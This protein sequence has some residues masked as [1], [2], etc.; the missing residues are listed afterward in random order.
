MQDHVRCSDRNIYLLGWFWKELQ[1]R[2]DELQAEL[3]GIQ[4]LELAHQSHGQPLSEELQSKSPG[5]ESDPGRSD[6]YCPRYPNW[7]QSC[8]KWHL[9]IL[10]LFFIFQNQDA[11][12]TDWLTDS[13]LDWLVPHQFISM[14]PT[15]MHLYHVCLQVLVRMRC[16]LSAWVW[17]LR[18]CWSSWRSSIFMK[19]RICETSLKARFVR[20]SPVFHVSSNKF[21][22]GSSLELSWL[23]EKKC[24]PDCSSLSRNW[25]TVCRSSPNRN[26]AYQQIS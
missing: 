11:W 7:S 13:Q 22:C 14:F 18:W 25:M 1:D 10:K 16:S 3:H 8:F 23:K 6:K 20:K 19:W 4:T 21:G 5:T 26:I 15:Q 24:F 17:K 12:L 2:I 9:M